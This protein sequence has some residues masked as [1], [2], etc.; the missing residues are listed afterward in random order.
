MES[1]N[2]VTFRKRLKL[3]LLAIIQVIYVVCYS[4]ILSSKSQ[5]EALSWIHDWETWPIFCLGVGKDRLTC[6]VMHC[7]NIVRL[8]LWYFLLNLSYIIEDL[9]KILSSHVNRCFLNINLSLLVNRPL[10]VSTKCWKRGKWFN[11]QLANWLSFTY[12]QAYTEISQS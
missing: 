11:M 3:S 5:S 6:G 12:M 7:K 1:E 4:L 10:G 2:S 9:R 8:Y